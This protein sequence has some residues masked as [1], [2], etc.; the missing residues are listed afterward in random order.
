MLRVVVHE[1]SQPSAH[2]SVAMVRASDGAVAHIA[3]HVFFGFDARVVRVRRGVLIELLVARCLNIEGRRVAA[4]RTW[5]TL[6]LVSVVRLPSSDGAVRQVIRFIVLVF[7]L[8]FH[9]YV[10]AAGLNRASR[11]GSRLVIIV[12]VLWVIFVI[13]GP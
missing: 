1:P 13:V 10:V 3:H 12:D 5:L 4:E 7:G 6:D 9:N 11:L 8:H 2:G